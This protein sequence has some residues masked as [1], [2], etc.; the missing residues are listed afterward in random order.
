MVLGRRKRR[1]RRKRLLD[2]QVLPLLGRLSV[3][4][5]GLHP[6]SEAPD[7]PVWE[8]A[9]NRTGGM[10]GLCADTAAFKPFRQPC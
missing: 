5:M 4:V 3:R 2:A 8:D 9:P 1:R 6:A 7:P 10:L